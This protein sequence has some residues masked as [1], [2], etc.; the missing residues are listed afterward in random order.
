MRPPFICLLMP[1][2]GFAAA[3]VPVSDDFEAPTI[4]RTLWAPS[5]PQT[6]RAVV[7]EDVPAFHGARSLRITVRPGDN[8]M[9]GRH[10]NA[11]E[12]FEL[13]LQ[14][15][16]VGFG[17][18]VWY[19][20]ALRV[21]ADFPEVNTRTLIHQFK[22][23]VRP[24]PANLPPGAKH[25][26]K[27][28]PMF[29]LY[30][31]PGRMLQARVTS[32]VDCDHTKHTIAE[33]MLEADRW[34]EVMVHTRPAHDADGMVELY[35][36]GELIGRYRGVMGY[37]CHGFGYIDTQPRFGIYRDAD[38]DAGPATLFYD[39]IRFSPTREGL[40]LAR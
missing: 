21:P 36:D 1:L 19:A 14:R 8:R 34:H 16:Q 18:E 20:F 17:E 24:V 38:P 26:E 33:H 12:R 7:T 22:E 15:P 23:N 25:C 5:G 27:A 9:V 2:A 32:S 35:L 39:S 6:E 11:T 40:R 4:V 13:T 30:L 10:G 28:S 37:V 3:P 31:K 29:A